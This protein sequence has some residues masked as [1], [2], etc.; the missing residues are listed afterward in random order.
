LRIFKFG[1]GNSTLWWA[2]RASA[3]VA[4]EDYRH[5]Y[6]Y[7]RKNML[8]NVDY[9]LAETEARYVGCLSESDSRFNVIVVDGSFRDRCLEH[10]TQRLTEDGVLIVDN[11]DRDSLALA[12]AGVER[13]GFR[14]IEFYGLGPMNGHP[15]GTSVLYRQSNVLGL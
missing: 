5:W 9:R 1:S 10:A 15:W 11:S 14:R 6:E 4:V 13:L 8:G 2:Q 7:V 3:V 12:L